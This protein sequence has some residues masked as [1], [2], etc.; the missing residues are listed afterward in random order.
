MIIV[1][2]RT[3]IKSKR[4]LLFVLPNSMPC[5]YKDVTVTNRKSLKIA[6]ATI[7]LALSKSSTY[8]TPRSVGLPHSSR[9]DNSQLAKNER[10]QLKYP[11]VM[12]VIKILPIELN[13]DLQ[14]I[15]S[16]TAKQEL[17]QFTAKNATYDYV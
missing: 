3:T 5:Y 7:E 2:Y 6:H 1:L 4:W 11:L 8:E 17:V 12:F 13:F 15:N 9:D 16:T 10:C 14:K